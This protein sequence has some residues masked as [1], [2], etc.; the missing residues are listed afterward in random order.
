[1]NRRILLSSNALIVTIVTFLVLG[2]VYAIA[3]EGRVVIDV[4]RNAKN[5]LSDQTITKLVQLEETSIPVQLTYFS[6][7]SGQRDSAS[8]K[9]QMNDLLSLFKRNCSA[10]DW[11]YVDFD[12]ERLTAEKLNVKEYG[13]L[14]IQRG[15][16]RVDIRERSLFSRRKQGLV[17][18]G[19]Q[20]ISK[21]FSQLL[22]SYTPKV[23]VLEGHAEA[24]FFD[25]TTLGLST[26]SDVLK[27]ERIELESLSLLRQK[28]VPE[29][30]SMVAILGAKHELSDL[31]EQALTEYVARGGSVLVAVD[32]QTPDLA[33]LS[34]I[35]F[36]ISKGIAVDERSMF[37][38][39]DRPIVQVNRHELTEDIFQAKIPVVLSG[40][41]PLLVTPQSGIRVHTLLSLSAKGWIDR[42]NQEGF[43]QATDER[44]QQALAFAIEI[45]GSS[46]MLDKSVRS[47]RVVVLSDVD[48]MR[49]DLVQEVSGNAPFL[50]NAVFWLLG[51]NQYRGS[52]ARIHL[53][54][55]AIAK[56][57]LPLLRFL[58]LVP[59]PVLTIL[60]GV[61]VWWSR[62]GR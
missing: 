7:K 24:S 37:P 20:Q 55:V 9:S 32:T 36:G 18:M 4:S 41:V 13:R 33:F 3:K 29:D 11:E 48:M 40:A 51:N 49:N 58:S 10:L 19:E 53:D 31:E 15:D 2:F 17:F 38:H 47:S 14:V 50:Y 60:M 56:P 61:L 16:A 27:Q 21:A 35:G 59:L 6:P 25:T 26:F 46:N 34:R 30:A 62:R 8:K 57:Q 1:M 12:E 23:Y 22:M 52:G 43:N 28:T 45:D 54:Q 44:K 5:T 39:W 42:D